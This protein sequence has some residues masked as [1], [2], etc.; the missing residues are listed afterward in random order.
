MGEPST[1]IVASQYVRLLAQYNELKGTLTELQSENRKLQDRV[2]NGALQAERDNAHK[3]E[4]LVAAH[5]RALADSHR[6]RDELDRQ[7][8]NARAEIQTLRKDLRERTEDS[9]AYRRERARQGAQDAVHD[10]GRRV[11]A[12]CGATG[13]DPKE[14]RCAVQVAYALLTGARV[15]LECRVE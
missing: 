8:T 11:A 4:Q 9:E 6:Q 2:T 13:L 3:I 10:L 5:T 1:E 12:E 15:P 7:L 14:L